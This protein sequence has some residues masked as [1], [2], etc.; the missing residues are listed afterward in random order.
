MRD[1]GRHPAAARGLTPPPEGVT[2]ED[3]IVFQE[4]ERAEV[5]EGHD[6]RKLVLP[7]LL[8]VAAGQQSLGIPR[9]ALAEAERFRALLAHARRKLRRIAGHEDLRSAS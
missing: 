9:R 4:H 1:R 2:L 5:A 7:E 6:E 8:Q 3:G